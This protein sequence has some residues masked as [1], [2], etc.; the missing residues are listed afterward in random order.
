LTS[1]R[2]LTRHQL[3]ALARQHTIDGPC[4]PISRSGR[5]R[6]ADSNSLKRSNEMHLPNQAA[7]IVFQVSLTYCKVAP[8]FNCVQFCFR[9][10]DPIVFLVLTSLPYFRLQ[11]NSRT[12]SFERFH[13]LHFLLSPGDF[14]HPASHVRNNKLIDDSEVQTEDSSLKVGPSDVIA[15]DRDQLTATAL[16]N[17]D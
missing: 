16:R 11:R 4:L 10:G 9:S 1:L 15:Q 14:R 3:H 7:R 6:L 13:V 12:P 17:L 2:S 5:N 8:I